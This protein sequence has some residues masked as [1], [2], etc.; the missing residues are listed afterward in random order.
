[1]LFTEL[2]T[3]NNGKDPVS[4][5]APCAVFTGCWSLVCCLV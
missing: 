3:Q 2:K 1:L 5:R 4:H